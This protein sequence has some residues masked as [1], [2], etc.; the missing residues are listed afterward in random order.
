MADYRRWL[1]EL[2]HGSLDVAEEIIAS[3]F[4]G[5][6]PDREGR[7]FPWLRH[8]IWQRVLPLNRGDWHGVPL[9]VFAQHPASPVGFTSASVPAG[10]GPSESDSPTTCTTWCCRT[11]SMPCKRARYTGPLGKKIR[12]KAFLTRG[13]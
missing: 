2:W 9:R 10:S 13:R 8:G 5:H 3:D 7:H 1:L 6:W 12:E 4:L 11:S